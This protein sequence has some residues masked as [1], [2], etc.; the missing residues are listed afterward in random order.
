MKWHTGSVPLCPRVG[1]VHADVNDRITSILR[2]FP[3]PLQYRLGL[4]SSDD[5]YDCT[6]PTM[7]I[8]VRHKRVQHTTVHA[9][10]Y[11]QVKSEVLG[12]QNPFL[13]MLLLVPGLVIAQTV[14]VYLAEIVARHTMTAAYAATGDGTVVKLLLLTQ[15]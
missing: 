1:E 9:F 12:H 2:E 3:E 6:P 10:V 7:G 15:L 11:R 5:G 13:G 4:H 8:L 14:P